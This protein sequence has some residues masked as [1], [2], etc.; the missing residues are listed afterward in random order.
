MP[1][2]TVVNN[3]T[4]F[5]V[6]G[7]SFLDGPMEAEPVL[8]ETANSGG[9]GA[10]IIGA[11][12][13]TE[14]VDATVNNAGA[15]TVQAGGAGPGVGILASPKEH[16]TAGTAG[17]GALAPSMT[18]PDGVLATAVRRHAGLIIGPLPAAWGVGDQLGYTTATGALVTVARGGAAPGGVTL[19]PYASMIRYAGVAGGIGLAR[20]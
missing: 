9:T 2:Q 14:T 15:V 12:Y 1:P 8:L 10:N 16:T 7:E 4:A 13:V 19:I 5:G 20:L 11:T 17:G 18:L 3:G 6:P